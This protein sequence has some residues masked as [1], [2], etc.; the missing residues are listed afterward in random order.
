MNPGEPIRSS[1]NR[2][3][4]KSLSSAACDADRESDYLEFPAGRMLARLILR[5]SPLSFQNSDSKRYARTASKML[6]TPQHPEPP[7]GLGAALTP[8][9]V[10]KDNARRRVRSANT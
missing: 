9:N 6:R 4:A 3:A 5:A 7:S 10:P 8:T 2:R 1:L